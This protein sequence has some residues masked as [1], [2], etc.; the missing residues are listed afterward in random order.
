STGSGSMRAERTA[1][2]IVGSGSRAAPPTAATM[3]PTATSPLTIRAPT[4][5]PLTAA[6]RVP[7]RASRASR[8]SP[9][10]LIVTPVEG[11][12]R[13]VAR[14]LCP[15]GANA[16]ERQGKQCDDAEHYCR[17]Q[18]HRARPR[19][20]GGRG[21]GA[22]EVERCIKTPQLPRDRLPHGGEV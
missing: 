13:V 15:R 7:P 10:S 3:T 21:L 16:A 18:R 20:F 9:A 8:A 6:L 19:R 5:A 1:P 12:G 17:D 2:P 11:V 14:S 22:L 4:R